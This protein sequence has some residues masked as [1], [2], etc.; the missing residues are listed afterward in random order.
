MNMMKQKK[1]KKKPKRLGTICARFLSPWF[2]GA[3]GKGKWIVPMTMA[4]QT[5][6]LM[7]DLR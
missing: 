5:E 3:A 2:G 1:P 4:P 7:A 6:G